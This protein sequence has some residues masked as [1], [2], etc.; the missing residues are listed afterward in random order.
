MAEAQITVSILSWLLED[1]LIKTL[2]QIPRNT[3][4]PLNLCLHVQ[5]SEQISANKKQEIL[6]ATS[7]FMLRDIFFTEGNK[8]AAGP[9][10]E[11][12]KRS[13]ITP[14]V[15]MTDNDMVFQEGSIDALYNF[16]SNP[17]NPK[18]G[19]V[20]LVHNYLRWHRTVN[21]T[22]VTCIPLDFDKQSIIEVDLIGA[23][24]MM[25][26]RE[27]ALMP[28]IM[29][30]NYSIGTWDFD[31][32]MNV[33]K[34]GWKIATICDKGLIALNDKTYR[35]RGYKAGRYY[36]ALKLKGLKIFE[37][38]WG[39]S[40]E[41]YP[42]SPKIIS[43]YK[44]EKETKVDPKIPTDTIIITRAIYNSIGEDP[45]IGVLDEDRIDMMQR[46][47]INSLRNQTDTDF[48]LYIA[49]GNRDNETV[50]RIKALNYGNLNVEFIYIEDDLSEWEKS[51]TDSKNWGR[52]IDNGC[53]EDLVRRQGHPMATIMA[54]IDIDDWATPGWIAHMKHMA[55]TKPESH[56]LINYQV[57]GQAPDG[58]L[59][60]F[61]APHNRGRSSS[62]IA[63]VQKE[64][65][66]IS[67]YL[68]V[69]LKMGSYFSSVYNIQPSYVFMVVHGKNRS[70]R[71][72]QLDRYFEDIV[73][74]KEVAKPKV[75]K[76]SH[77][78]I[79]KD[80]KHHVHKPSWRTKINQDRLI[81]KQSG[82]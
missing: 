82:G 51:V 65:P 45:G 40:S 54:R 7:G 6:D 71:L 21:G 29:D 15:F 17:D 48:T 34:A 75:T 49:V 30:T 8:G 16:I 28:D 9:R 44:E 77:I 31:L 64:E 73:E 25:M 2:I 70:N 3:D 59:Y 52:E 20:D 5:A 50:A 22:E 56:F 55:S 74:H 67:P 23:G 62:F 80:I 76:K 81:N 26:K 61:F 14:Y 57:I 79:V 53:P 18:F 78:S 41:Y 42:N 69:H 60:K 12:L 4:L 66:R 58:R 43:N 1:R 11:L 68:N 27:V 38:K 39:F 72:Y 37:E 35:A 13:A 32:C 46:Y 63:L 10:A 19:I 36:N 33:R 47:F 24:S